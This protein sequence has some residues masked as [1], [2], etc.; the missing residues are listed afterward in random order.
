MFLRIMPGAYEVFKMMFGKYNKHC[1]TV[2]WHATKFQELY[3]DNRSIDEIWFLF[4]WYLNVANVLDF[5]VSSRQIKHIEK[6]INTRCGERDD[7]HKQYCNVCVK[8]I[9]CEMKSTWELFCQRS[10]CGHS[11]NNNNNIMNGADRFVS[12]RRCAPAS[13][14]SA[15]RSHGRR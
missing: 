14:K 9:K 5:I 10:I 7:R 11:N 15:A 6:K 4:V 12:A 1:Y 3:S 8:G 13:S 2:Y